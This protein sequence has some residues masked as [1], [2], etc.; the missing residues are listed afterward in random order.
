MSIKLAQSR[1]GKDNSFLTNSRN[2]PLLLEDIMSF[3]GRCHTEEFKQK[4][5]E[6]SKGNKYGLGHKHTKETKQKE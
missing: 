6:R 3:Q 1:A 2:A 4:L 5:S